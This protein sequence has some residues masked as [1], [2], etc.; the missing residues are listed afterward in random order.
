MRDELVTVR[1]YQAR[2]I[3][4]VAVV[5]S[6]S[7]G[8]ALLLEGSRTIRTVARLMQL[9]PLGVA[10]VVVVGVVPGTTHP[11]LAGYGGSQPVV[12][13]FTTRP[14]DHEAVTMLRAGAI[15]ALVQGEFT[16]VDLITAVGD[17]RRGD[18]YLS[19]TIATA[20]VH[21]VRRTY[22]GPVGS[23]PGAIVLSGIDVT[24]LHAI[25]SG[26]SNLAIATELG[27]AVQTVRNRVS[28]IYA[29]IGV[30]SR[31]EAI[32]YWLG[33]PARWPLPA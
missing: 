18:A 16:R 1:H 30:H 19:P 24:I 23:D 25:A 22:A 3:C 17:A 5:G 2:R 8:I 13:V 4:D 6:D 9:P 20:A 27:V 33:N 10:D 12:V 15:G 32:A 26:A 11:D 21:H 28:L 31:G 29:K 7:T 14:T